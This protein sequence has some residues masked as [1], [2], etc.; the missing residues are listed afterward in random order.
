M[1]WRICLER[2]KKKPEPNKQITA[3]THGLCPKYNDDVNLEPLILCWC[4]R[5]CANAKCSTINNILETNWKQQYP[6][7]GKNYDS[8]RRCHGIYFVVTF[9]FGLWHCKR[10]VR[11][12]L[13]LKCVTNY[14][15]ITIGEQNERKS[16][17]SLGVRIGL[18]KT[19]RHYAV[20]FQRWRKEEK[21]HTNAC[22]LRMHHKFKVS[23]VKPYDKRR[24]LRL[25]NDRN[26]SVHTAISICVYLC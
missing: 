13:Q 10:R 18:N 7:I 22:A 9:R 21:K 19:S 20:D 2:S 3:H 14:R 26:A 5:V 23:T 17:W 8:L 24:K 25:N 1:N 6:I 12:H 16:E 11:A 4:V 15:I